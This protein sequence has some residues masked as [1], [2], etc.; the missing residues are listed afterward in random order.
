MVDGVGT[1]RYTY[2]AVSQLL[3]EDGPW[4]ADTVTY[5]Y[6]APPIPKGLRPPAQGLP[7]SCARGRGYPG[8]DRETNRQP[9]RGCVV[10]CRR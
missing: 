10:I 2:T 8:T 6:T 3:S 5:G 1:T 4:N 7:R 9:Q